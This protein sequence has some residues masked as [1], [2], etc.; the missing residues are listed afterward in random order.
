[1]KANSIHFWCVESEFIVK[2]QFHNWTSELECIWQLGLFLALFQH[3]SPGSTRCCNSVFFSFSRAAS[4]EVLEK[5]QKEPIFSK[6]WFRFYISRMNEFCLLHFINSAASNSKTEFTLPHSSKNTYPF[7]RMAPS[8]HKLICKE[9]LPTW[10][11]L[12]SIKKH[13]QHFFWCLLY[14]LCCS[15]HWLH[16]SDSID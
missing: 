9:F 10:I 16:V 14:F 8:V 7:D 11:T 3:F 6:K 5:G 4:T 2:N 15:L 12:K 13:Y 1:M